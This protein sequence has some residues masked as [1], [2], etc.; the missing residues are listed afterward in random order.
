MSGRNT[1]ITYRT[2]TKLHWYDDFNTHN[3][4]NW[5][6]FQNFFLKKV[7]YLKFLKVYSVLKKPIYNIW[8]RVVFE[9]KFSLSFVY[10]NI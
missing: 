7:D 3:Q 5:F 6:I 2:P 8:K 10:I 1:E 4:I 9:N